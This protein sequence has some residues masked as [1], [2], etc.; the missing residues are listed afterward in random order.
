MDFLIATFLAFQEGQVEGSEVR[1][2]WVH[3]HP[4][5]HERQKNWMQLREIAVSNHHPWLHVGDLQ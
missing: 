3:G 2:T 1:I 4:D 5:F